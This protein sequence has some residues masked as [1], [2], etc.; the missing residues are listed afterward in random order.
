MI[1][2]TA[3]V[4]TAHASKYVAQLCK[5]WSHKLDVDVAEERGIVRFESAVATLTPRPEELAVTILANDE[6]TVERL[7]DVVARHLDRFAFREAPLL[8]E[9]RSE[10]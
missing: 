8:F 7:Q 2:R 1:E 6:P 3:H 9:W 5:H 4:P 10:R